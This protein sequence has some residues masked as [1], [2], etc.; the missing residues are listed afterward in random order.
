[1]TLKDILYLL[2]RIEEAFQKY[3]AS[4]SIRLF[5]LGEGLVITVFCSVGGK[6]VK[7]QVT[8][9]ED[10]VANIKVDVDLVNLLVHILKGQLREYLEKEATNENP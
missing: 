8:L 2:T 7:T 10:M 6:Q 3:E 4:A 9:M 5:G 1:M